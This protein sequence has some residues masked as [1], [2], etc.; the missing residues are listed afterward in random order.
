M[1]KTEDES[2]VET[3]TESTCKVKKKVPKKALLINTKNS[4]HAGP[5]LDEVIAFNGWKETKFEG[6]GNIYWAGNARYEAVLPI[7]TTKKKMAYSKI[8]EL[9]E[10]AH[11]SD[12]AR[13]INYMQRF[14]PN[15]FNF[16]PRTFIC[17]RD[18][19]V[20]SRLM[21]KNKDKTWIC[22]PSKGA[23]GD[24]LQLVSNMW[25]I[26]DMLQ[27][28]E[29]IIQDYIE[30]PLLV[31]KK[32]FD[33]RLY[34]VVYGAE[35][36]TAYLCEEGMSRFC[37]VDYK[38][39]SKSNRR[40]EFMHLSNYSINKHSD[41]YVKDSEGESSTKRKLSSIYE[42]I[43]SLYPNGDEIVERIKTNI[44]DVCSKTITAIH[45]DIVHNLEVEFKSVENVTCAL[46]QVIGVD[47][48]IDSDYKAWLLE[49]NN[50]PSLNILFEKD[51]MNS[52]DSEISQ[53]D[54]DI[55]KPML[56]DA[57]QLAQLF[58]KDRSSLD[59]I[60]Q[61]NSLTKI[62]Y[63]SVFSPRTE[64]DVQH[65]CKII[66]NSLSGLKGKSCLTSGQF[67]KLY[68]LS[69]HISL[70]DIQKTDLTLAFS[71]LVG[72]FKSMMTLADFKEAMF[73]LFTKYQK[74]QGGSDSEESLEDLFPGFLQKIVED[75]NSD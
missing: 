20:V 58:A 8:P 9:K 73:K 54:L 45:S 70:S 46:F 37:T 74:N 52:S 57:I 30:K 3:Q 24:G 75:I 61:H 29:F 34:I 32:K 6:K 27:R 65:S 11:K 17:P 19:E 4:S 72:R 62:Y 31:D 16:V 71:S 28:D 67:A 63:D 51:F 56:S 49:I 53:I 41:D 7:L 64:F 18:E 42:R 38:P 12:L 1:E 40:N 43:Q 50:N 35:P 2:K 47:I 21:K 22:K 13:V 68:T 36:M 10:I 48:M 15:D 5:L 33:L 23:Q 44:R 39:P 25:E 59:D 55:K 26:S 69:E 14:Y 60:V 66:Y